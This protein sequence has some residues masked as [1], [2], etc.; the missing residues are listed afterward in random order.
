MSQHQAQTATSHSDK[1]EHI[2]SHS[3]SSSEDLTS[4]IEIDLSMSREDLYRNA[5][6]AQSRAI[7]AMAKVKAS[8]RKADELA[9]T[10]STDADSSPRKRPRFTSSEVQENI[11]TVEYYGHKFLVTHMLWLHGDTKA[12]FETPIDNNYHELEWSEN[13]DTM[14]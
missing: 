5:R 11:K 10:T 9:T 12:S 7:T 8:H 2:H 13:V 6:R 14:L 3:P 4:E 1:D